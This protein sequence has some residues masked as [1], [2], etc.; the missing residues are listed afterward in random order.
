MRSSWRNPLKALK[1]LWNIYNFLAQ[2]CDPC[3]VWLL[4]LSFSLFLACYQPRPA[5][6]V[7]EFLRIRTVSMT[8]F[9]TSTDSWWWHYGSIVL[10]WSSPPIWRSQYRFHLYHS[11]HYLLL[12]GQSSN[13]FFKL[14]TLQLFQNRFL[15]IS[16][17][18]TNIT[19]VWCHSSFIKFVCMIYWRVV[20]HFCIT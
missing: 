14:L 2:C 7:R 17:C 1:Y 18:L 3:L 20:A 10:Q 13:G 12:R 5:S 6:P 19:C 9:M 16:S 4:L 8:L 11:T 15:P